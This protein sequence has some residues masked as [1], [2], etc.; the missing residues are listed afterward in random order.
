MKKLCITLVALLLMLGIC[1]SAAA[2]T[3]VAGPY[4]VTIKN[5]VGDHTYEAYQIF[6]GDL[7]NGTLS[8]VQWGNGVSAAGQSAL[9]DAAAL[10]ASLEGT[11]GA[12]FA[13]QIA[14]YLV[15]DNAVEG[16]QSGSVAVINVDAPGYYLIKD[17]DGSLAGQETAA[18]PYILSVLGKTEVSPKNGTI[19]ALSKQV[20]EISDDVDPES[21]SFDNIADLDQLDVA[22]FRVT[23]TLPSDYDSYT[24]YEYI[25][26]DIASVGLEFLP[27][28]MKVFV[29]DVQIT[30]GFT[31]EHT[32]DPQDDNCTFELVFADMKQVAAAHAGSE[33]ALEYGCLVSENYVFESENKVTLEFSNDVYSEQ[34]G[35]TKPEYAYVYTYKLI[36][37]KVDENNDPLSGAAFK[38]TKKEGDT[39]VD[40]AMDITVDATGT[41]FTLTGLDAGIYCLTETT[42]P[43]GYNTMA[44]MY[45]RI[46]STVG[47][48]NGV[49]AVTQLIAYECDVNGNR[50]S[51][52]ES[53]VT[54]KTTGVITT[55]VVNQKGSSLPTTGGIG[56]VLLY[57]A[58]GLLAMI[59]LVW[60]V[61]KKR[62]ALQ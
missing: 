24:T 51:A 25:F 59:A 18:T 8:N 15:A 6:Q 32:D 35:S 21:G 44:P 40:P 23:G 58:G 45:F 26:H 27:D 47:V 37:N 11:D 39:F 56:T 5:V 53:F 42:T 54:D 19:P 33:I 48:E 29:D 49:P 55:T 7:H 9:G 3:P 61:T 14:Q 20:Q 34:T 30:E 4:S 10:A 41:V 46:E 57:T 12:V 22:T 1:M 13:K 50:L 36:L 31:L 16:T 17:A 62:I 60:F 28:T 2:E 43:D 52:E 38:V